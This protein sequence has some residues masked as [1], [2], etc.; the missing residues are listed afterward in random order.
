M[1]PEWDALQFVHEQHLLLSD[2]TLLTRAM[3]RSHNF[4]MVQ[5]RKLL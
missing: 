5:G 4:D 1:R 2:V 3:Q